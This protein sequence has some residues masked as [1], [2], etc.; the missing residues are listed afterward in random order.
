MRMFHFSAINGS[1]E[2]IT[3]LPWVAEL[4][5]R[6]FDCEGGKLRRG[7]SIPCKMHATYLYVDKDGTLNMWC[8][9][10]VE[11][12]RIGEYA[13]REDE[14]QRCHRWLTKHGTSEELPEAEGVADAGIPE[15]GAASTGAGEL[16]AAA[17]RGD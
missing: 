15:T 2:L 4:P 17:R 11:V 3:H 16:G 14:S 8:R 10:H 9:N 13:E 6:V 1:R 7:K 5:P 12:F